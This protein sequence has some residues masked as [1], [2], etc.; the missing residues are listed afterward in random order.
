VTVAYDP[1]AA[2]DAQRQIEAF[3]ARVL[4]GATPR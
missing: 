1:E 3:L 2:A 4:I